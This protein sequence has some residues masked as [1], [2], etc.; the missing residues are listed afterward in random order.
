MATRGVI[1]MMMRKIII[2]EVAIGSEP[3]TGNA[4]FANDGYGS[5]ENR[6]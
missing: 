4:R 2:F 5:G 1:E 3:S 6:M